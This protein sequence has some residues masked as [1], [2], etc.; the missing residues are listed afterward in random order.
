MK[1]KKR[2]VQK[3]MCALF[4]HKP[5]PFEV[6]VF[7]LDGRVY[8]AGAKERLCFRCDEWYVD[9]KYKEKK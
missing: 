8:H 5:R 2:R 9:W 1:Y 7:T 6:N 3:I 4:G